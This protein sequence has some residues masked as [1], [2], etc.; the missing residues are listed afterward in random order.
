[1]DAEFAKSLGV[2]DGDIARMRDEIRQNI[3][4]EV[5]KRIQSRVKDQVMAGLVESA[6][7]EVPRTLLD[8]EV[9]RMHDA[10]VADLKQRG[11]TT[12]GMQLPPSSSPNARAAG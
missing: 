5:K 7:F 8:S 6:T 4:R 3:E 12:Q 11:M 1:M 10:A 9:A 2:D